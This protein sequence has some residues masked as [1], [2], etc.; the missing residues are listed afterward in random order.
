MSEEKLKKIWKE[1]ELKRNNFSK[2]FVYKNFYEG[3]K[4]DLILL[5]IDKDLSKGI[6]TYDGVHLNNQGNKL[7]ADEMIKFLD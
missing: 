7:I 6:L 2:D 5:G 3:S 4:K 1:V